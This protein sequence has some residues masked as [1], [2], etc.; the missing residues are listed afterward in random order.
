MPTQS[1]YWL[2][3]VQFMRHFQGLM[4]DQLTT[5]R[6]A[7]D[8]FTIRQLKSHFYKRQEADIDRPFRWSFASLHFSY[9]FL[10]VQEDHDPLFS[11]SVALS[12]ITCKKVSLWDNTF[13]TICINRRDILCS[14]SLSPKSDPYFLPAIIRA[15]TQDHHALPC[16][17]MP[18][19]SI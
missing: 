15:M 6:K 1:G 8:R 18:P 13:W 11:V 17:M 16:A 3:E 19:A 12:R 9:L 10:Y 4:L 14:I 2:A 7:Y 5:Q